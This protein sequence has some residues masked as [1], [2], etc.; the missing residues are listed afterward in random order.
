M[1]AAKVAMARGGQVGQRGSL[2]TFLEFFGVR[3]R[4]GVGG[5]EGAVWIKGVH[6]KGAVEERV[7]R[8]TKQGGCSRGK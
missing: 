6:R 3:V 8:D 4:G 1:S 5:E 2:M 7:W